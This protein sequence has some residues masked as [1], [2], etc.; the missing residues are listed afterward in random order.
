MKYLKLYENMESET[1]IDKCLELFKLLWEEK[2]LLF[3]T[4]II[5]TNPMNINTEY[6]LFSKINRDVSQ[7]S[8]KD[9]TELFEIITKLNLKFQYG[10]D[11]IDILIDDIEKFINEMELL[12]NAKKYNV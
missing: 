11:R 2:L 10:N 8:Y 6:Q 7:D 12:I 5:P 1:L 9:F 3:K 4:N